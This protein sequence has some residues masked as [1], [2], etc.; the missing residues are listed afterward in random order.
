MRPWRSSASC[1]LQTAGLQEC[2]ISNAGLEMAAAGNLRC[3]DFPEKRQNNR[4]RQGHA[5]LA[6]LASL[7]VL[8]LDFLWIS[9][10]GRQLAGL[11]NLEELFLSRTL[12]D[13]DAL[14][15][16]QFPNL[17]RLRIRSAR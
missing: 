10:D 2:Q 8:G 12:V 1:S 11:K 5:R 13:G 16:P 14:A 17:K 4:R 3:C 15:T 7:K 9:G 6:G